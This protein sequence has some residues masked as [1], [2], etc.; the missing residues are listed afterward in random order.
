MKPTSDPLIIT[1]YIQE[2]KIKIKIKNN[3]NCERDLWLKRSEPLVEA[4][5]RVRCDTRGISSRKRRFHVILWRHSASCFVDRRSLHRHSRRCLAIG[6]DDPVAFLPYDAA[7]GTMFAI[8]ILGIHRDAILAS[9]GDRIRSFQCGRHCRHRLASL[10]HFV[11]NWKGIWVYA[12]KINAISKLLAI[13]DWWFYRKMESA[14]LI[15]GWY[16]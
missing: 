9:F 1:C 7:F 14:N 2:I 16:D 15:V 12:C 13:K 11:L 4:I 10:A 3:N 8:P 5:F 6:E